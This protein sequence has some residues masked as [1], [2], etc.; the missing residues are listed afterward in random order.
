[1]EQDA[2]RTILEA[3]D[4]V[5]R[6]ALTCLVRLRSEGKPPA[7]IAAAL[8]AETGLELSPEAVE[9]VMRQVAGPAAPQ[10]EGGDP[11]FFSG[12]LGGG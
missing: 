6:Q 12:Y 11:A 10:A 2:E 5:G 1:M 3:R 8:K 4:E 9:H 7:E